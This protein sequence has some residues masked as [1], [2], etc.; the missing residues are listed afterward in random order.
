MSDPSISHVVQLRL[1]CAPSIEDLDVFGATGDGDE[2]GVQVGECDPEAGRIAALLLAHLPALS[3]DL[4]ARIDAVIMAADAQ[5]VATN[6]ARKFASNAVCRAGVAWGR[7]ACPPSA[8]VLD[9]PQLKV[10]VFVQG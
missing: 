7:V 9:V 2:V 8:N 3:T 4:V 1:V 5:G 6:V 10:R